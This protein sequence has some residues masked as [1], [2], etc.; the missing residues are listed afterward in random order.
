ML[1]EFK[2]RNFRSI[3]DEVVLDL[4]ATKDKTMSKEAVFE[5][6]KECLL[7]TIS[8]HGAN[9][10]GKSNIYRAFFVFGDMIKKSYLRSNLENKL[11]SEFFKLNSDTQKKSSFFEAS[12]VVDKKVFIYG[13]EIDKERVISEW[14]KKEKG[15]V[16]LFKRK[17]QKIISNK[18]LFKEATAVLKKQTN[19]KSLFISVL[20]TNNG[21]ISK[22]IVEFFKNTNCVPGNNRGATLNYS[23]NKFIDD[24]E[25][26][27][28]MKNFVIKADFGIFD[29]KADQRF[30]GVDEVRNIPDKFKELIFKEGSKIAERKLKFLHKKYNDK[31]KESGEEALDFFSEESEGTQQFFALS[32]P[33]IDTLKNGK[34][35]F[36][37][38]IN[39]SLHPHLCQYLV[40][41]FNSKIENPK[42][43]QL[44]FTTHD[45]SLLDKEILRRDQ[46]YFTNKNRKGETELFSLC[47]L[48]ERKNLDFSKRYMEGR[49]GAL[50]YL[51]EFE[52]L[53]FKKNEDD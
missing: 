27:D 47:D 4:R 33:V 10:S 8:I 45:I 46:I 42:N 11:P 35:L 19:E 40:S 53:K 18:N 29:I 14:L 37:D 23:F 36:I 25:M 50:P 16:V 34:I 49:Y 41:I 51:E 13:F 3:K 1:I 28:E 5:N 20:A 24:P 15:K 17:K 38:E 30:V 43:A 26:N 44:I 21:T 52:N 6:G 39:S 31:N 9:A 22:K 48:S 12:F 32:A 2:T 7:K